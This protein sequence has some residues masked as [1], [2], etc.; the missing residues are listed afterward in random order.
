MNALGGIT[1]R[2]VGVGNAHPVI[3]PANAER[4]TKTLQTMRGAALKLG[5]MLSIQGKNPVRSYFCLTTLTDSAL[6]PP[7]LARILDEVRY[8]ADRMTDK[9]LKVR[10]ESWE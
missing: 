5:Q 9:Q 4:L 8:G 6:L 1:L 2:A 7:E 10:V 3:N